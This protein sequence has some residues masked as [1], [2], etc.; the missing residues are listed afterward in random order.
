MDVFPGRVVLVRYLWACIGAE[1]M[2]A[3]AWY[4]FLPAAAVCC[5]RWCWSLRT[6]SLS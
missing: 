4:S 5:L 1:G 2:V 3:L 6:L